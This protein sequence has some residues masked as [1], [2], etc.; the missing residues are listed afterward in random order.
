M[1]RWKNV[2]IYGLIQFL[3]YLFLK[4]QEPF[5]FLF[6]S[7]SFVF[8]GMAMNIHNNILDREIDKNKPGYRDFDKA[9]YTKIY[10]F[11]LL[12]F[13]LS[14]V[15]VLR[16]YYLFTTAILS[17]VLLWLYNKY[18]K[19]TRFYGNFIVALVVTI[20]VVLPGWA[21]GFKD[22]EYYFLLMYLGLY[23]FLIN[24]RR[25]LVKDMEDLEWDKKGGYHTL[26]VLDLQTAQR[27]AVV[28]DFVILTTLFFIKAYLSSVF[29]W[30]LF[31]VTL[32]LSSL[33]SY[34][35]KK[36][37]YKKA[38]DWLKIT[39]IIGFV[40]ILTGLRG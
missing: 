2:L 17:A 39:M 16:S 12:S 38:A 33:A 22:E 13:F 26:A 37:Q 3:I 40:L 18:L 6:T 8:L 31:S 34:N 36:G 5:V 11:F 14:L 4:P 27:Y 25:E 7:L 1:I 29:F 19:K 9:I 20:A 23:A 24:L 30:L 35:I 15:F 32:V 21:S 10:L 28:I